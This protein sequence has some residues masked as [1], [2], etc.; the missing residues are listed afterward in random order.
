[1]DKKE[2]CYYVRLYL[3]IRNYLDGCTLQQYAKF[4]D[5][6]LDYG[7]DV[8]AYG[9]KNVHPD[10]SE[11]EKLSRAWDVAARQMRG[12]VRKKIPYIFIY[13]SPRDRWSSL[14]D[15]QRGKLFKAMLDYG[16]EVI[17][18]NNDYIHPNFGGDEVLRHA[19]MDVAC[20]MNPANWRHYRPWCVPFW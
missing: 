6:I 11:D 14:T 13:F 7:Q 10:F 2:D 20:Q 16:E 12:N 4:L 5:A 9:Y 8:I 19:W 17:G 3:S 18:S 15:N 1:M